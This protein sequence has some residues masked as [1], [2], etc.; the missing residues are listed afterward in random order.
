M[1]RQKTI[2]AA[3]KPEFDALKNA[4]HRCHNKKHHAYHNYGARG[5]TV[6]DDLRTR[7]GWQL[8]VQAIGQRPG[9]GYSL[10]RIDNDGNYSIDPPNLRWADGKTQQNNRR[11]K[12]KPRTE[13]GWGFENCSPLIEFEGRLRTVKQWA[14]ELGIHTATIM[15]RMARK[16]PLSQVLT[17]DTSRKGEAHGRYGALLIQPTIH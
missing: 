16:L 3:F 5:I 8:L 13:F 6:Q 12:N 2:P 7:N 17:S 1:G 9:K 10:D 4:I 15:Q 11:K 14:D